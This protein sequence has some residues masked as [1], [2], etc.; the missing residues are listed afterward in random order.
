MEVFH[1][2]KICKRIPEGNVLAIL[3]REILKAFY[4][5]GYSIIKNG[6]IEDQSRESL[7]MAQT[8]LGTIYKY[9]GSLTIAEVSEAI[10]SG[11][12][13]VYDDLISRKNIYLPAGIS[14]LKLKKWIDLYCETERPKIVKKIMG[15]EKQKQ[16]PKRTPEQ[17]KEDT[18]RFAKMCYEEYKETG[19]LIFGSYTVFDWLEKINE[20]KATKEEIE[21][22]EKAIE[23]IILNEQ[24]EEAFK[25]GNGFK[26]VLE[27]QPLKDKIII[28][29][30][31]YFLKKYFDKRIKTNQLK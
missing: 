21:E 22:I 30:K 17:K 4:C 13:G 15:L 23:K 10:E 29:R 12:N 1:K 11:A 16:I 14:N 27:M 6:S 2:S 25:R 8:L 28:R 26:K 3:S 31:E 5:G 7:L 20:I 19:K 24:K 9:F 18:R